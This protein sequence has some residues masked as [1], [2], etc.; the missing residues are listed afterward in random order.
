[1][2]STVS[3]VVKIHKNIDIQIV[4]ILDG[5]LSGVF[6]FLLDFLYYSYICVGSVAM[7]SVTAGMFT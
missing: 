3:E 4:N 5:I 2:K 6:I 1:V 7:G